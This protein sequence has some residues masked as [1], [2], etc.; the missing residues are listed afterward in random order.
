VATIWLIAP[1][2]RFVYVGGATA[3]STPEGSTAEELAGHETCRMLST[4][5]ADALSA[6]QR[7]WLLSA[8]AIRCEGDH[9]DIFR[10]LLRPVRDPDGRLVGL[11]GVAYEAST[12]TVGAVYIFAAIVALAGL[13]LY[14]LSLPLWVFL[15]ARQRGDHACAWAAFVLIGNLVALIAYV[16][17]QWPHVSNRPEPASATR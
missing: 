15:D 12:G 9:N 1:D 3:Q 6:E 10:H 8:A 11:I 16:L 7:T 4:L 5:P 14:W 2:R 17:A 13:C